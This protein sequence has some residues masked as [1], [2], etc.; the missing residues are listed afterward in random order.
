MVIILF[1]I[2]YMDIFTF[3]LWLTLK[4]FSIKIVKFIYK[5]KR[6]YSFSAENIMFDVTITFNII[7]KYIDYVVCLSFIFKTQCAHKV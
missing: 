1:F 2:I 4:H 7:L 3:K 6:I 5:K